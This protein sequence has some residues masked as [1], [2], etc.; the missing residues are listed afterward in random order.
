MRMGLIGNAGPASF[1]KLR[2]GFI[3]AFSYRKK[4]RRPAQGERFNK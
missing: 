3:E 1:G 2:T 4:S